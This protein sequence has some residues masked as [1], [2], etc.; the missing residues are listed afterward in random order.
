MKMKKAICCIAVF[1]LVIGVYAA[2]VHFQALK[3]FQNTM[4]SIANADSLEVSLKD[5]SSGRN[6]D[7]VDAATIEKIKNDISEIQ[8][9]GIY[10]GIDLTTPEDQAYS[11][12]VFSKTPHAFEFFHIS[13]FPEKSRIIGGDFSISIKN[14]E[15]LY[16]TVKAIFER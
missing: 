11:V 7:V 4:T 15:D 6:V 16:E 13:A 8:F 9:D 10:D 3:S 14:Y 1:L 2:A 12:I 5:Y